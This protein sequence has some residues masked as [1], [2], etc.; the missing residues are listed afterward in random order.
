[1]SASLALQ[2]NDCHITSLRVRGL[3]G[4]VFVQINNAR[5]KF[6]VH[7]GAS[8]RRERILLTV[9]IIRK[10]TVVYVHLNG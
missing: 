6:G 4:T 7:T 8:L 10:H 2:T 1:M 5:A 3:G 9:G